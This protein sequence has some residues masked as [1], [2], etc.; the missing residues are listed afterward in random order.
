MQP[1]TRV[2]LPLFALLAVTAAAYSGVVNAGYILDDGPLAVGNATLDAP[3][4]SAVFL[5]DLWAGVGNAGSGYHR[6]LMTVSLLADRLLTGSQPW[7]AHLQSLGWH[8]AAIIAA[9]AAV[10]QR[11]PPA[12]ALLAAGLFAL[13]PLQSEAVIWVSARNDL[14]GAAFIFATLAIAGASDGRVR[15][16]AAITTIAAC[17]SKELGYLLPVAWVLWEAAWGARVT[18]RSAIPILA[19]VLLAGSVRA[20]ATLQPPPLHASLVPMGATEVGHVVLQVASWFVRPRPLTST[21]TLYSAF[22]SGFTLV[23][24]LVAGVGCAG[25]VL[26]HRGRGWALVAL[27]ILFLAPSLVGTWWY[28]VV[29]ERYAYLAIFPVAVGI[30]IGGAEDWPRLS[31]GKGRAVGFIVAAVAA[32]AAAQIHAR[33]P[34]WATDLTLYERAVSVAPDSYSWQQLGDARARAG[35]ESGAFEANARAL[36]ARPVARAAC[37][38]IGRRARGVLGASAAIPVIPA[39]VAAGCRGARDFDGD[40]IMIL[41]E[42]QRWPEAAAWLEATTVRDDRGRDRVVRAALA[43]REGDVLNA[44]LEAVYWP[45]GAGSMR[46][47]IANLTQRPRP[48]TPP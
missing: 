16:L 19:G 20:L 30:A 45:Q 12:G 27:A 13:H 15:W 44:G 28:A 24:A 42:A 1:A 39:W 11:A 23:T 36:D 38:T 17:W 31:S 21:H 6:P 48:T 33:V 10:V 29:G 40:V 25:L 2:H 8:L 35:D 9:Y 41:V 32:Y 18:L 26:R 34:D 5:T 37:R 14:M 3:T 43:D 7:A 22:P 47:H 46:G 4:W